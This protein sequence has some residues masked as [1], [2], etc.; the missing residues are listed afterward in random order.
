MARILT[1]YGCTG[2]I[3]VTLLQPR[4]DHPELS[5]WTRLSFFSRRRALIA[6]I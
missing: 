4:T 6:G 2:A 5:G 3:P 1:L